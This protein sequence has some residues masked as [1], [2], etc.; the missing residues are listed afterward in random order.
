MT[1]LRSGAASAIYYARIIVLRRALTQGDYRFI[2]N[3]LFLL[4]INWRFRNL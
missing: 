2:G 1:D 4:L 3:H